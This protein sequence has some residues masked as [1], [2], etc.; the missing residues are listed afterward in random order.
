MGADFANAALAARRFI[1]G[2]DAVGMPEQKV[3]VLEQQI[4]AYRELS[5]SPAH[6]N[7]TTGVS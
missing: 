5:S 7:A 6:E 1:A 2:A 3:G 4:D